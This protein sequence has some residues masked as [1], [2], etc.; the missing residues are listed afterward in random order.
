MTDKDAPADKGDGNEIVGATAVSQVEE[1]LDGD[2]VPDF[3][4]RTSVTA[5]DVDGDGEAD[6][7]EE[8]IVTA[9]DVDGDGVVDVVT[10]TSR[11]GVDLDGDGVPDVVAVVDAVG[12]D[13]DDDG[14]IAENEIEV[15]QTV[16]VRDDEDAGSSS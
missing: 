3:V 9:F 8:T 2:G 1:D 7:L 16:F 12:V 11:A 10:M 15:S 4:E 14:T 5:V 13:A 6:L